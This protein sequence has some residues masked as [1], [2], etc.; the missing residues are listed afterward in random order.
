MET[1]FVRLQL[2]IM[3][4]VCLLATSYMNVTDITK[5]KASDGT[6]IKFTSAKT[7]DE[8]I[9]DMVIK[10]IVGFFNQLCNYI[11]ILP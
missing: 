7:G 6:T 3:D 5:Y 8:N 4:V 9:I 10:T 1:H 11:L 2:W